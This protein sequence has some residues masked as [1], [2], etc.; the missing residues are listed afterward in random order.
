MEVD[1]DEGD[2]EI[3]VV[4]GD[5]EAEAD[6]EV[7]EEAEPTSASAGDAGVEERGTSL[8]TG[9]GTED[10]ITATS[11]LKA[12]VPESTLTVGEDPATVQEP[13]STDGLVEMDTAGTVGVESV[14]GHVHM[15]DNDQPQVK[16]TELD[17]DQMQVEPEADREGDLQAAVLAQTQTQESSDSRVPG[18]TDAS[19]TAS[20]PEPTIRP[21][22]SN[23][24]EATFTTPQTTQFGGSS[25]LAQPGDVTFTAATETE[26]REDER[27]EMEGVREPGV[28][29]GEGDTVGVKGVMEVGD[30]DIVR[31]NQAEVGQ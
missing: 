18:V 16:E 11:T 17:P 22:P 29:L 6:G 13:N 28:P 25:D 3:E 7:K 4:E 26:G 5:A 9:T 23:A 1:E 27:V 30:E 31:A 24:V 8:P 21:M 20:P 10:P 2:A 19:E 14:Q 12:T 15:A